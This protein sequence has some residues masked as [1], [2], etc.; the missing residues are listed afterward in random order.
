MKLNKLSILSFIAIITV[1]GGYLYYTEGTLPVNKTARETK[2]FVIHPGDSLNII[3]RNLHKEELIR[4]PVVFYLLVKQ[5]GIDKKIQAGDFRISA[6]MNAHEVAELLT[7]GTLD[8]WVTIIEGLRKEEIAQILSKKLDIPE[9]E[10]TK[11]APEGYLFPDTYLLPRDATA[12]A[13][14][15]ILTNTFEKRF[16][17]ELRAKVKSL[18]LTEHQALV[19]ASLVEREG[20]SDGVRQEIAG[21]L[22]RRIKEGIPLQVDATVQYA[23]GYQPREKTWWKK[24][25]TFDDLK[26]KSVYNTYVNSGLP[27]EPIC[28]PSLSALT[29]VANADPT[30]QYL[31]YLTDPQGR[32]RYAKNSEEHQGNIEKYLK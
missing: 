5:K 29:A 4:N 1:L 20:R 7:H 3:T 8:E 26:I 31:F 9:V 23:L 19:L 18:G 27:P 28:N 24:H 15:R 2:I 11:L 32:M 16:T 21:I 12:E 17:P 14:I 6:S 30:T 25:L 10:F 13:V 22:L